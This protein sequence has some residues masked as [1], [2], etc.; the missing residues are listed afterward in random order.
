[1]KSFENHKRERKIM[2]GYNIYESDFEEM[3]FFEISNI[4]KKN[5]EVAIQT[6]I[7]FCNNNATKT[8]HL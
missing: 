7:I 4:E 2:D 5:K 6:Q 1:L 3:N 8:H